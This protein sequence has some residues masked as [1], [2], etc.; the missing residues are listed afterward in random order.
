MRLRN[1]TE[2]ERRQELRLNPKQI[3]NKTVKVKYKP[4]GPLRAT[5]ED[6]FLKTILPKVMQVNSFG[7]SGRTKY[8]HLVDQATAR[9]DLPLNTECTRNF[10]TDRTGEMKQVIEKP[11]HEVRGAAAR[12]F[13]EVDCRFSVRG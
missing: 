13:V 6:H 2:E 8:S 1:I 3:T 5:P 4:A 10:H 11:S 7:R 9:F 12:R